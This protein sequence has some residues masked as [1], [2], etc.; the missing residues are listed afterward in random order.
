MA[1]LLIVAAP[2]PA[3]SLS[4]Q[5]DALLDAPPFN[6]HLWGIA[7]TD[8][9]G[10]TLYA[11][12]A[13]KLFIPASNTKLVVSA[14]ATALLPPE[15]TVRTSLYGTGPVVGGT[16]QGHLVLYGRGDPS[17]SR[18]CFDVDTTRSGVCI[19]DPFAPLR[20]LARGLKTGGVTTVLG[21]LV[22]DGSWFEPTLLHPSWEHY[23][24]AW[25]Y[26]APV[27]GLGFTDNSLEVLPVPTTIGAPAALTV[28]PNLGDVVLENRT[29]TVAEGGRRTLE[30]TR[31]PATGRLIVVGDVP[32]GGRPRPEYAAVT[33]PNLYAA[34]ALRRVLAEEGIAVLG[35]TRS[36]T[37][38]MLFLSLRLRPPLA[39][40]ESRP[41]RDWIFPVLNTSQNWFAEMLLKQ[42]G[43]QFGGSGSWDT[44]REVLHRFLIDSVG[45]DSTQAWLSDG[46][47][48]SSVNLI[49]PQSFVRILS[50][51]RG[52]PRYPT[53]SA[54]LPRSGQAGSLRTRFVGTPLEGQVVAKTGSISTVN[55]LSGYLERSDGR[56]LVFSIQANHHVLGGRA[57]I[58]AIDSIVVALA[59]TRLTGHR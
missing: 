22:G 27:S 58:A 59:K 53:F 13:D 32:L 51:I 49:S 41:V 5:L 29:R 12:N 2:L 54:G 55:T 28:W 45:V 9:A 38:S 48:L 23:D 20:D 14:A 42:L 10:K 39:E 35:A 17:M 57:M 40:V 21:D 18:R 4:K 46:S 25:W 37:D 26:A 6:R 36:T 19:A 47:G 3:Q 7:V 52:H 16:L 24:L 31:E 56:L 50:W 33:D 44:G 11:R 1:L 43:R 34:M 15:M 8:S 30:I